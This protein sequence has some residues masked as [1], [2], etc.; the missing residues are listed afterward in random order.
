[1]TCSMSSDVI[2]SRDPRR[3]CD[4]M[5]DPSSAEVCPRDNRF[6]VAASF[7]IRPTNAIIDPVVVG[8]NVVET[9]TWKTYLSGPGQSLR[10][11]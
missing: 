6:A 5:S 1:M 7:L 4:A 11:R 10:N 2:E 3:G 9:E 8:S